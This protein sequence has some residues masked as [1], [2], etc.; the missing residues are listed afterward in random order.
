MSTRA[1]AS[2]WASWSTEEIRQRRGEGVGLDVVGLAV[3]GA[4]LGCGDGVGGGL[5]RALESVG[6]GGARQDQ[7][8]DGDRRRQVVG[9]PAAAEEFVVVREGRCD[10]FQARPHG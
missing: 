6:T 4:V 10:G 5:G 7:S 1:R 2:G 9:Y 8:G 3:E